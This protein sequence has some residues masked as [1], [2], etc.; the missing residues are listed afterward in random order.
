MK[1]FGLVCLLI[2]SG[3][4]A[5]SYQNSPHVEGD[6]ASVRVYYDQRVNTTNVKKDVFIYNGPKADEVLAAVRSI[7]NEQQE[8]LATLVRKDDVDT[9]RAD[10]LRQLNQRFDSQPDVIESLQKLLEA[11]TPEHRG[12]WDVSVGFSSVFAGGP[13]LGGNGRL[14][15][16]LDML[17]LGEFRQSFG[18]RLGFEVLKRDRWSRPPEGGPELD[19]YDRLAY[20]TW[21]EPGYEVWW[22]GKHVGVQLG[23]VLGAQMFDAENGRPYVTYG[24]TLAPQVHLGPEDGAGVRLGVQWRMASMT[25]PVFDF[26]GLE[27]D[28]TPE[29]TL[30]HTLL[31]YAGMYFGLFS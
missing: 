2:A 12:Y 6:S 24:F 9:L 30:Q 17:T 3:A 4:H 31:V 19:L 1:T 10:L 7:V 28:Q 5:Q 20:H 18:V 14:G 22:L 27:V 13:A 15:G 11:R 23:F 25:R 16:S 26:Q 21:I 8:E 29:R